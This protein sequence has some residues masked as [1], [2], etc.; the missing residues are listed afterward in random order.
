[1]RLIEAAVV[2]PLDRL[3]AVIVLVQ[4]LHERDDDPV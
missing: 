1:M 2:K 3:L 4:V